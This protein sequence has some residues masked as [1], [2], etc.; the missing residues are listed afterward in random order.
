MY[1]YDLAKKC[2]IIH[3]WYKRSFRKIILLLKA[4][5]F[6]KLGHVIL[7]S[8]KENFFEQREHK[9]SKL[10]FSAEC[11][12]ICVWIPWY[13]RSFHCLEVILQ[14]TCHVSHLKSAEWVLKV[15]SAFNCSCNWLC[16]ILILTKKKSLSFC[17]ISY[18]SQ[19]KTQNY[20][21]V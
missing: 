11:E 1:V 8:F 4:Y 15:S 14:W 7:K 13:I 16:A 18:Y 9:F 3:N 17:A 21:Y 5:R 20:S 6:K 10:R 12:H 2:Y 19:V